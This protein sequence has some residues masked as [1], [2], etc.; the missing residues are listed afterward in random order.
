MTNDEEI[1]W[2]EGRGNAADH[3]YVSIERNGQI[4]IGYDLLAQW[5]AGMTRVRIGYLKE[6]GCV[7]IQPTDA[8]E[9][10]TFSARLPQGS[11]TAMRIQGSSAMT[12]WGLATGQVQRCTGQW[13]KGRLYVTLPSRSAKDPAPE[14]PVPDKVPD[15]TAPHD[16]RLDSRAVAA[17]IGVA[18]GT[19][20]TLIST[21]KFPRHTSRQGKKGLWRR[22]DVEEW[23]Q[24]REAKRKAREDAPSK[25]AHRKSSQEKTCETCADRVTLGR[26][27]ICR[28]ES[29]TRRHKAVK[30]TDT[31]DWHRK[32]GPAYR[33]M[34]V[35][36]V[37]G[38]GG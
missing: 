21:G 17:R 16:D 18:Q 23:I 37:A 32:P 22:P 11:R 10:R 31:C 34:D 15:A 27:T 1:Q 28:S 24:E 38:G 5:P 3:D 30:L 4:G 29:S 33:P 12:A 36:D 13:R 14:K 9:V 26:Q 20:W 6:N 7:V 8:Q 35:E 2:Y 25:T 19:L